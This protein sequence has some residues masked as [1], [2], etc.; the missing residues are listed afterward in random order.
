MGMLSYGSGPGGT[1][2][3]NL[4]PIRDAVQGKMRSSGSILNVKKKFIQFS[5]FKLTQSVFCDSMLSEEDY[6]LGLQSRRWRLT[7]SIE[8]ATYRNVL[9]E[10]PFGL[11]SI[12]TWSATSSSGR[13]FKLSFVGC[14]RN[15]KMRDFMTIYFFLVSTR[16]WRAGIT[17]W[18]L[19][20]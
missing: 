15:K 8:M 2:T 16:T 1:L 4:A 19:C 20:H 10:D 11:N 3:W 12:F 14:W 9:L 7:R 17:T 5:E 18:R 13:C 6:F